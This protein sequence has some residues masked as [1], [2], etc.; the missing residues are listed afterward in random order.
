MGLFINPKREKAYVPREELSL[1]PEQQH[2]FKLRCLTAS[3]YESR[4]DLANEVDASVPNMQRVLLGTWLLY[5]LRYG[6]VGV[7][8]A[9]FPAPFT[10][11]PMTGYVSDEFID[12]LSP[13]V[14]REIALQIEA[15]STVTTEDLK[16]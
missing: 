15:L 3:H 4:K 7:E 10:I 6:L 12:T 8:G 5:T 16:D 13:Q 9:A 14:R 11:D 1:P 2:R